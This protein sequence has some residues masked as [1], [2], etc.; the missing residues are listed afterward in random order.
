[1][2]C[3]FPEYF[4]SLEDRV[5]R[6]TFL[7][8]KDLRLPNLVKSCFLRFLLKPGGVNISGDYFIRGFLSGF[9]L[10][11]YISCAEV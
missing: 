1:M 7:L 6:K 2:V 5:R 8:C 4:I 3:L 10:G 11:F 9:C